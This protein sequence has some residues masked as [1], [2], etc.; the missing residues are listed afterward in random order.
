MSTFLIGASGAP[1]V[2]FRI[3]GRLF[4][5]N[6]SEASFTT[7]KGL[8]VVSV[9]ARWSHKWIHLN[10]SKFKIFGERP[11]GLWDGP[12]SGHLRRKLNHGVP[13]LLSAVM[14]ENSRKKSSQQLFRRPRRQLK[15]CPCTS[16]WGGSYITRMATVLRPCTRF[17]D[18]SRSS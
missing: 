13:I 11:K 3:S 16:Y 7:G 12:K 10:F 14:R 6:T 5:L 18:Y 17:H 8:K 1:R 15:F 9:Y 4:F 2:G